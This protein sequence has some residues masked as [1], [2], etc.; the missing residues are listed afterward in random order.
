MPFEN[1]DQLNGSG[2]KN[3]FFCLRRAHLKS[4]DTH[5]F[6]IKESKTIMSNWKTKENQNQRLIQQ[7]L[8]QI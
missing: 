4:K 2:N 1:I 8:Y 6:R 3:H 7:N 5:K